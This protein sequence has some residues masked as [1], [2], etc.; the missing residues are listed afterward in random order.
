MYIA[1]Q[2]PT[3]ASLLALSGGGGANSYA[4]PVNNQLIQ[5]LMGQ[6]PA[7]SVPAPI[8]PPAAAPATSGAINQL[9]QL[10]QGRGID[11]NALTSLL[12]QEQDATRPASQS[13]AKGSNNGGYTTTY[14][15]TSAYD[16]YYSQQGGSSYGPS[17]EESEKG[18]GYR[19]Y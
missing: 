12:K 19:P 9:A 13:N 16:L 5:A 10:L 7:P 2:A 8:A 17:K 1:V 4:P 3:A 15:P 11:P 6:Q 14:P 18:R